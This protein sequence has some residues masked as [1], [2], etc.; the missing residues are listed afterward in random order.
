M[1]CA[2]L[3]QANIV[4]VLWAALSTDAELPPVTPVGCRLVAN[5]ER[6]D[7][8]AAICVVLG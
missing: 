8:D 3:T 7:W 5:V 6:D 1:T 2:Q 4:N